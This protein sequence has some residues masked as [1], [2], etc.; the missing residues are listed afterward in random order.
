MHLTD[1]H[2]PLLCLCNSY[3]CRSICLDV[4]VSHRLVFKVACDG[5]LLIPEWMDVIG[6]RAHSGLTS[7]R[8]CN[9]WC[10]ILLL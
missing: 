1:G 5:L 6:M 8:H 7:D 2:S 3:M 4:L 9:E 10:F